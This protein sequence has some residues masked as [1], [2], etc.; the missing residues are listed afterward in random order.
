M[1]VQT[2]SAKH[3]SEGAAPT[4]ATVVDIL[5]EWLRQHYEPSF[6]E[7]GWHF[8]SSATGCLV[9]PGEIMPDVAVIDAL[10]AHPEAPHDNKGNVKYQALP[11]LFRTWNPRTGD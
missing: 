1:L 8:W 10:A 3:T 11:A 6:R 5:V 2:A 4:P 9:R 7:N